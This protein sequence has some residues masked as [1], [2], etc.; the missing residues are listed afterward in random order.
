MKIIITENQF[1]RLYGEQT[2][3]TQYSWQKPAPSY[4][5]A[6]SDFTGKG[7]QF[8]RSQNI[9]DDLRTEKIIKGSKSGTI[10]LDATM[11]QFRDGLFSPTGMAIEAFLSAFAFTAP[12]VVGAYAAMLAY[13]IY[14]SVKGETNWLNIIFD[15]F[16]VAT[17]GTVSKI[18]APYIKMAKSAKTEFKT[19]GSVFEWIKK[20]DLWGY[21]KPSIT[22]ITKGLSVVS[23]WIS[24]GLEW[25]ANNTGLTAINNFS[26]NIVSFIDNSI[27]SITQNLSSLGK[28]V[29]TGTK[30]AVKTLTPNT[31]E[32]A[33]DYA[34][35][36]LLPNNGKKV[37]STSTSSV[38]KVYQSASN[39][40]AGKALSAVTGAKT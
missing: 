8:E 37:S 31:K 39:S 35:E 20:T 27:A 9:G 7:G 13:D 1:R 14:K 17:S 36:K 24:E 23:K 32:A 3:K 29:V 28:K 21:I 18:L 2:T 5:T 30:N 38:K 16:S 6:P 11:E 12:A 22:A 34:K 15:T 19:I 26:K 4:T 25:I 33:V 10:T 40:S